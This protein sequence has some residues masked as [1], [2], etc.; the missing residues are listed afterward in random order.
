MILKG[1]MKEYSK[2]KE[3][4][5]ETEKLELKDYVKQMTLRNARTK[6]RLRSHILNVKMN[7]KADPKNSE[8]LWKCD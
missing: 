8:K 7:K 4:D 2:L 3:I 5:F 1:N 6:F